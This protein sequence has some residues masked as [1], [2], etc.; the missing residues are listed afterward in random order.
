M[1][2]AL[3]TQF[4]NKWMLQ[5]NSS[6]LPNTQN[7]MFTFALPII[8]FCAPH[9]PWHKTADLISHWQVQLRGQLHFFGGG[10]GGGGFGRFDWGWVGV[11][12]GWAVTLTGL[13]GI[14]AG[15]S[16]WTKVWRWSGEEEEDGLGIHRS[17][18]KHQWEYERLDANRSGSHATPWR[19]ETTGERLT[20][21]SAFLFSFSGGHQDCHL[22]HWP[23]QTSI[24]NLRYHHFSTTTSQNLTLVLLKHILK[25]VTHG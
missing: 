13:G 6:I 14:P 10:G 20:L 4:R 15:P 21:C 22:N 11:T 19:K 24:H 25:R 23:R 2:S 9:L 7:N 17:R 8:H 5:S 12:T 1:T 3:Q 16:L 18:D